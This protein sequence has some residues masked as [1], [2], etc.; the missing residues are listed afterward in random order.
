MRNFINIKGNDQVFSYLIDYTNAIGNTTHHTLSYNVDN[1]SVLLINDEISHYKNGNNWCV[2]D[3]LNTQKDNLPDAF[4]D[5]TIRL[6]FP[7]HGIDTYFTGCKYVLT[8]NTWIN[9]Y[10]VYL[11]SKIFARTDGLCNVDGVIKD[12]NNEYYEYVDMTI[13][14]PYDIVYA[15]RWLEFRKNICL[16]PEGINNTGSILYITLYVIDEDHENSGNYIMYENCIGGNNCFNI[17][18]SDHDYLSLNIATDLTIPGWKL[19]TSLNSSYDDLLDYFNETY[20]LSH[21]TI[22]NISYE[23]IIKNEDTLLLGPKVQFVDL[24]QSISIL[25]INNA[26]NEYAGVKEFF[27]SWDNYSEGCKIVCCLTVTDPEYNEDIINVLSNEIPVTQEIFKFF[28][29]NITQRVIENINVINYTVVNKIENNIVQIERLNNLSSKSNIVQPV[30]FRTKETIGLTIHPAVTENI[31]INLDDYKSKVESFIL[32]IE[33]CTFKQIGA[34]NY[35]II[36][37][38]IGRSLPKN[39]TS[40]LYYILNEN[41]ELV[42]TGKYKYVE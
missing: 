31:C 30:F 22:E 24:E 41:N 27:S 38:V 35:G 6:Y 37:K 21:I 11:G 20:G 40:G 16:E 8:A 17:S 39:A 26:Q 2:V 1:K 36:F 32:Q 14:D 13:V 4:D 3:D 7:L 33:G 15:D 9:G 28:V 10:K 42:T 29:N 23:M 18:L 12:G 5:A 19:N 34:N 25:D